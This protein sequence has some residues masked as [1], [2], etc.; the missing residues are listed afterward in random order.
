ME[1][2]NVRFQLLLGIPLSQKGSDTLTGE[3]LLV[4]PFQNRL[5]L[6]RANYSQLNMGTIKY[7]KIDLIKIFC[8]ALQLSFKRNAHGN[9][10][11]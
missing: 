9:D 1:E 6:Q 8:I 2:V 5:A 10:L 11:S 3:R 4:N 7:F